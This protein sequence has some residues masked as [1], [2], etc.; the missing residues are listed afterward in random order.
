MAHAV[1]KRA[2]WMEDSGQHIVRSLAPELDEAAQHLDH[3]DLAAG[4]GELSREAVLEHT[5]EVFEALQQQV[6]PHTM[7][8]LSE[9]SPKVAA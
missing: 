8:L 1:G 7:S 2:A 4:S 5:G 6:R 9:A 3:P